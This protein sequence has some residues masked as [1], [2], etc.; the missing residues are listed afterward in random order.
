MIRALMTLIC[1]LFV[2]PAYS[3]DEEAKEEIFLSTPEQVATLSSEPGFLV[4]GIVSPLSG[5]PTLRQTDFIVKGAQELY[6][7]RTYMSPHMP[8]KLAHEKQYQEEWE[9]YHLYQHV[10]HNYKGWQFYPHL[11]LQFTPSEKQVLV[12]EPS[13]S[14]LSFVFTGSGMTNAEFEGELYGISNCAGDTP[15]G[16]NDP[17]NTRVTYGEDGRLITVYG[18]DKGTRVY[19]FSRWSSN[20]SQLYLLEKEILANGKVLKYYYKG[21]QLALVESLDPKERF[22]Y[23]CIRIT[24]NPWNGNVHF[25]SSSGQKADYEYERRPIHAKISKKTKHWYGDDKFEAEYNLLC[26]PI[27]T[28]VSSPTFRKEQ[29]SHCG[30][31]LLGSYEGRSQYFKIVNRGYGEGSG[32]YRV[33]HLFLPVGENDTFVPVYEISYQPPVAGKKGGKTTV[34]SSDG[35]SIIYHFSKNLLTSKIE[36]FDEKESLKK[37][38]VFSWDDKNWLK[39]LELRDG[40]KTLFYKKSF[41]YDNFGNP[42]LETFTG[43]LSGS[44]EIESTWTKR[45]FSGDGKNLLLREEKENSK[46]ICYSYLKGTNLIT[47]KFIKDGNRIIQREFWT[48]DDCH[49]LIEKISDD[50]QSENPDDLN[51]VTDRH[52]TSYALRQST[53]FLHMPEWVIETY[54][55]SGDEKLLKKSHLIYD[56]RGNV[57]QEEVYDAEENF[58]YTI[59]KTYNERGDLLSETDRLG[60]EATYA[61]DE[62][63]RKVAE[64]NFSGRLH[65]SYAYDTKGRLRNILEEGDDGTCHSLP[66]KYDQQDHL[67]KRQDLFGNST[68]YKYDPLVNEISQ[69]DFPKT[70]ALDGGSQ[71]VRTSSTFDPFGREIAHTDAN[72][73]TTSYSY[74]AYGSKSEIRYPGGGKETFFYAKNGDLV[75]HTD[76][77][78]LTIKYEND[79]LGRVL[80]RIYVSKE[81]EDLAEESFT[82]NNFH[83]I[84]ETDKEGHLKQYFYD[85]AGRKIREKHCGRTAEFAYDPLSRLATV[86]KYVGDD[87]LVTHYERD[88]EDRVTSETK[89]DLSGH[90]LYKIAFSYDSDGNRESITRYINGK[91]AQESFAYDP[92]TRKTYYR[93]ALGYET[94]TS[95]D[96]SFV[97]NLGQKVLQIKTV[98]SE[99]VMTVKTQD[100]LNQKVREEKLGSNNQT[101]SCSEMIYDPHGNLTL[102]KDHLY[103]DGRFKSTQ[104][105]RYFYTP[106]HEIKVMIRG[107]DTAEKRETQYAYSPMGKMTRKYLPDGDN[108][109]Y[110]YDSLGFLAR[111]DSLNG[112][113]AHSFTLSKLGDLLEAFDEKQNL[114]IKREIDSFGNVISEVLPHGVQI[115]R[116]YDDFNRL[117]TLNV[118]G[119]AQVRYTYD[120]MFLKEIKRLSSTGGDTLYKHTYD[121]YDQNGNLVQESLIGNL[122]TISY[123]TDVRGQRAQ[124]VSPYFSEVCK[125]NSVQNLLSCTTDRA[126]S[127]YQYDDTS[128]MTREDGANVNASYGN[129][130]LYNRVEKDGDSFEV[131]FL[132]ELLSDGNA[133]YEYDLR[134]N[135]ILKSMNS[136]QLSFGYDPLNQLIEVRSEKEK[137]DFIY[138]PLGRRLAKVISTKTGYG[139]EE[140]TREYYLYDGEEEIGSFKSPNT[141]DSF[142]VLSTHSLPK[143][144]SIEVGGKIFAPL[145]DVQGNIRRLV[146]V[147]SKT[148]AASYDFTAFGEKLQLMNKEDLYNPWQF[149]SKRFDSSINLIYFG[150]RYYNPA[151]GRWITTDPAG[152]ED[153]FNPY[154]YT[155]N[156]PFRYYDPNGESL[157]GYMLGLGEIALGSAILVGGFALEVATVGGFTIGIGLTTSTGA[158]LIG[159]GLSTT[160]YHAQDIKF[161]N[162]SWKNTDIYVPDRPLPNTPDGVHVP[163]TDVPHTQLGTK[164]GRK[165]K[166]PQAREFDENGNPVRDIDFTDHGRPQDHL[167]PHQHE[168]KPNPTGGTRI[169]DPKGHSVTDWNYS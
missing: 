78:G 67:I 74:N 157:G 4:G 22:V 93:D 46:I 156:N 160:T 31:F 47:S 120:C 6:L 38:K 152:F 140:S 115:T 71:D 75:S 119:H 94:V 133:R 92:F 158:A 33:H 77:D 30:R 143:T 122:G 96:E 14:T 153:S 138:D 51:G 44:G 41:E 97:N 37:E 118:L 169:R 164:E 111:V 42:I 81:G 76:A 129:D 35:T 32:H 58:A 25:L 163:D 84:S 145:I 112:E 151:T 130:S 20:S 108:L 127:R 136:K 154:Q 110:S 57:I 15:G 125:Y 139:W 123:S 28:K 5:S 50:G 132:N 2:A 155:L 23:A 29:I 144:L 149:A 121:E 16:A 64:T 107:Y 142:R 68:H 12:T 135:Q 60:Q 99:G 161:P 83:L 39:S 13:G 100:A 72:G 73:N 63:G 34:T 114:K 10:A 27:L 128:Q 165:G 90:I 54:H 80:K 102:H 148:L 104:G 137:V 3:Y 88:L 95:Y 36:Y 146:D 70:T 26:P 8:V 49:N 24:G 79:V 65:K 66:S 87:A 98:D 69:T 91:E 116:T 150:K 166:Y 82:Y 18:T 86:Y 126:E 17:R 113:I 159:A 21:R 131:N 141:L 103:E 85:G 53:P 7:S 134:G 117:Q 168:H 1:C 55:D 162:I 61:Y 52:K 48:Y 89:T 43:D 106:D 56:E 101:V 147:Y 167:N 109:F 19:R 59:E 105:V 40:Q 11:K 62:K 124:M 9:K 45:T